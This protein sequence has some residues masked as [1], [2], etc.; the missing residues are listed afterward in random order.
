MDFKIQQSVIS[1]SSPFSAGEEILGLY[2]YE[3]Y[4]KVEFHVIYNKLKQFPQKLYEL[5]F[6]NYLIMSM[7]EFWQTVYACEASNIVPRHKQQI[8]CYTRSH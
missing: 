5:Y 8:I 1:Y 4:F 2:H 7:E 3:Y 6:L